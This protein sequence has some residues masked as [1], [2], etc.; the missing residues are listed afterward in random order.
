MKF[1][2]IIPAYN[3]ANYIKDCVTSI[4]REAK[5]QPYDYEVI[6][7]NNASTDATKDIASAFPMVKVVDEPKKGLT[8]A[9]QRGLEEARGELLGYLD[10]DTRLPEGWFEKVTRA[11]QQYDNL[12]CYSGPYRYF[13]APWHYQKFLHGIWW[14]SAPISY[15]LVGYMVLGGNFVAKKETLLKMGGF[16]TSIAF[17][18]EDTDIARRLSKFGKVVF[19]MDFFVYASSRRFMREGIVKLSYIY[20][21]NFLWEVLFGKPFTKHYD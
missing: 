10:A 5:K 2:I 14:L 4:L 9:R 6:V 18:G 19:S 13:D 8:K 17:Y 16:N 7:V 20:G 15:R 21:M 12:V 11:Y 3:E 1:S